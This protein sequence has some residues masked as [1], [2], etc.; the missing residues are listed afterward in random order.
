MSR[1]LV[2]RSTQPSIVAEGG[3]ARRVPVG[4]P[5]RARRV[6]DGPSGSP[7][8]GEKQ[9]GEAAKGGAPVE[10]HPA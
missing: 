2:T 8:G 10:R 5:A 1:R 7:E 4:I 3:L 6:R 9:R